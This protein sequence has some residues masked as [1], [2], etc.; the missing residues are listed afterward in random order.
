MLEIGLTVVNDRSDEIGE[1]IGQ[2]LGELIISGAEFLGKDTV[3]RFNEGG[4]TGA[5]YRRSG[6]DH[7][8]SA[9]GESPAHWTGATED[10]VTAD[11]ELAQIDHY[12]EVRAGGGLPFTEL[13]TVHMAPRPAIIPAVQSTEEYI[14][15]RLARLLE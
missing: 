12:A 5:I 3:R 2:R 13:G 8:A 10:T 11:V 7:Q 15:A 14:K 6:Q 9:P 4:K 1:L